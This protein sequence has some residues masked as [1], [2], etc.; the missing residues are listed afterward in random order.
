MARRL[1]LG[2]VGGGEGGFFGTAHR[3]AARL[4]DRF[5]LVAGAFSSD[6]S[7]AA[8][9]AEALLVAPERSYGDF[10]A[11]AEAE[12]RRDDGIDVVS[13]VL[14]NH[15]HHPAARAFLENG[16]HVV[17]DKPVT[18]TLADAR[19]LGDLASR[20]GLL[21]AVTYTNAGYGIVRDARE[22]VASGRLGEI[23][24]VKVDFPQGWL[25]SPV[26]RDGNKPAEWRT[27]P[28]R[29]GAG[30]LA[31]I[32][33]HAF[34]LAEYVSGLQCRSLLAVVD[35]LVPGRRVDDNADLLLRFDNGACGGIWVSQVATGQSGGPVLRIFGTRGGLQWKGDD[36]NRLLVSELDGRTQIVERA[37]PQSRN[38]GRL[39]PGHPEGFVEALSRI[40]DDVA[41]RLMPRHDADPVRSPQA[42]M[43]DIADGI[44]GLMMVE[45]A[46]RSGGDWID[47]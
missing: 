39:P 32:G 13:V 19:D 41:D 7:K 18:T 9:S 47:L 36:P 10:R 2:M 26:E 44:R 4:T 45:A 16:I 8:R 22:I 24:V 15:L 1:R 12:A 34:H 17:C 27:D 31:D 37:G 25:S 3:A 23:R 14:P 6:A 35:T 46:L 21:F 20:A 42:P 11:M 29:S 43:P 40:Y 33:T 28:A 38:P 5:E 30:C